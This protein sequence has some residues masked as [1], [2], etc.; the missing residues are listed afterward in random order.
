[1]KKSIARFL[2]IPL[3]TF[4]IASCNNSKQSNAEVK[5]NQSENDKKASADNSIEI[6]TPDFIDPAIK[7]YYSSYTAYLKKVVTA[8]RNK[9]DDATMKLFNE[10]GKQFDNKNEME[11]KARS[12]PEK[13]QKFTT[14]LMQSYPYQK[15]II[16]SGVYKK[17]TGDYYKTL[18]EKK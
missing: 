16:E 12:T 14:W 9:D 7:Q 6:E 18:N 4:L 10:E 13:E 2:S 8:I 3:I 1:M 11:E 17:F 5:A 15:E